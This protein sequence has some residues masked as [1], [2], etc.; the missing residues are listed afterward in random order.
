MKNHPKILGTLLNISGKF[1]CSSQRRRDF[2]FAQILRGTLQVLLGNCIIGVV[3]LIPPF[4]PLVFSSEIL[5]SHL[6]WLCS[7]GRGAKHPRNGA[8]EIWRSM[9]DRF[10]RPETQGEVQV[11]KHPTKGR[12]LVA[13]KDFV[14]GEVVMCEKPLFQVSLDTSWLCQIILEMEG[15][16]TGTQK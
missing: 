1:R 14:R 11:E 13:S 2:F 9:E 16:G 8:P 3:N 15:Q 4:L 10:I 5:G 12:I 6:C 7:H